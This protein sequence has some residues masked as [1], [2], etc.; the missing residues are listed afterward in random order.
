MKLTQLGL[1]ASLSALSS[2]AFAQATPSENWVGT[3]GA[4]LSLSSGNTDSRSVLLNADMARKTAQDK[5]SIVSYIN[6]AS[7]AGATTANRWALL[8][9]YDYNLS[10]QIY[11]FGRLGFEGDKLKDLK[12]RT[13]LG[14]GLGYHV[15]DTPT[16]VFNVYG[17]LGYSMDKYNSSRSIAGNYND[18]FNRLEAI[19]GEESSHKLS[20]TVSFKQ[21]FELFGG[22]T[23]DK[24]RRS[25]LSA[26]LGVS[27]SNSMILNVGL[28]NTYTDT[29][30]AGV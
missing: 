11:G 30:P 23:G 25:Q 15:I 5:T 14:A 3:L 28:M 26:G 24:A 10:K 17:G 27:L 4:S 18:S 9:Q 7:S 6:N 2:M 13:S 21:K 16:D 20:S 12:L 22:L 29:V 8:G 1:I 19:L